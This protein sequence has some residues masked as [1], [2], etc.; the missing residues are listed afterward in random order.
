M[1]RSRVVE[2][3]STFDE[4][5]PEQPDIKIEVSLRITRDRSNVMKSA[6]LVVHHT[7]Y[8]MPP[9]FSGKPFTN[10]LSADSGYFE[11]LDLFCNAAE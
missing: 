5:Q 2:I 8:P 6:N 4:P 9:T 3:D 1:V 11:N 10:R 7:G